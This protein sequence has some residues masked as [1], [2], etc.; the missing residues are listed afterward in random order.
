MSEDKIDKIV[1]ASLKG[2]AAIFKAAA[3]AAGDTDAGK[4]T[5]IIGVSLEGGAEIFTEIKKDEEGNVKGGAQV[6]YRGKEDEGKR[7]EDFVFGPAPPTEEEKKK[8]EPMGPAPPTEEEERRSQPFGPEPPTQEELAQLDPP[9]V[10]TRKPKKP[11][12]NRYAT[13]RA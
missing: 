6:F 7:V 9:Q 4:A 2:G 10:P 11:K 5:A 12:K 13:W 8:A 1:A 3:G